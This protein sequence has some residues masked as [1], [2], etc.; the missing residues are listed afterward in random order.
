METIEGFPIFIPNDV[1]EGDGFYV[2]YN[3]RDVAEYGSDTTALVVG[4]M[5]HFYILNGDHRKAYAKLIPEGFEACK[6]YFDENVA[7][8]NKYSECGTHIWGKVDQKKR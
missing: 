4:Q 3:S 1:E 2:S 6:R 5:E 7:L 8:K